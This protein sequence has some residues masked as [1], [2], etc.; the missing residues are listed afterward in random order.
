MAGRAGA[1]FLT[2]GVEISGSPEML[3]TTTGEYPLHE[4]RVSLAGREWSLLHTGVIL[5][6]ADETRFFEEML[7]RIPY[8]VALWPSSIAL[9]MELAERADG[10]RGRT[11]LELGAGT[12]L[13]GLVAA[14]LGA[15]VVQTDRHALALEMCRRNAER[16]GIR[17]VDVR[18]VDWGEWSD[19]RRYDWILGA[20]I[21][22]GLKAH[23]HVR[24]I[25]ETNLAPGGRALVADPFRG[26]SPRFFEALEADGWEITLTKWT[27]AGEGTPRA[28]G[29]FE[30]RGPAQRR[31]A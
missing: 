15:K 16:N 6:H 3:R 27:L 24:R 10:L 28:F 31:V 8:G 14:S 17:G 5:S 7:D 19:D 25:F 11:V 22:Y 30:A 21:L 9:A 2:A 29:V 13:P 20:D 4:Y 12:G 26:T 18:Q 1:R 23:P